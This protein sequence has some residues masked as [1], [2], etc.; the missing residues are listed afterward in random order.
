MKS[1]L[2]VFLALSIG[3]CSTLNKTERGAAIGAAAGAAIGGLI[4]KKSADKPVTGA[5]IG[6]AAGGVVGAVIGRQMDKQAE[7]LEQSLEGAN[8]ERVGEGIL[9]T[10]DSAIL[11][12]V[13]SS[14]MSDASK[15]SL[16]SLATSLKQYEGTEVVVAG[17][18]DASGAADYN[19]ALSER[20]AQAA[21]NYLLQQAVPAQRLSTVGYGE[22]QPVTENDTAA[23]RAQNR[24]VEI[25]IYATEEYRTKIEAQ[26]N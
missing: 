14:E 24:R 13:N 5:I 7:E 25:A 9:V 21:A 22:A 15:T 12:A 16:A 3:A 8:V 10:F 19:Q 17:H 11:F 23:G 6:A 4:G 26:Q 20:R 18:T 2:I 1:L